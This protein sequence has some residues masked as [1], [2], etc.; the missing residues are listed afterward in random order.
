MSW[1]AIAT[2]LNGIDLSDPW[3]WF[4]L[5]G[6]VAF[7]SRFLVQWIASERA[8]DSV[9]PMA[10]WHL[11]IVGSLVMLVYAIHKRDPVFMLAYLPNAFVYVRNLML[12]KKNGKNETAPD[13]IGPLRS[14]SSPDVA[15]ARG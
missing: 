13:R 3:L 5:C 6:N 2:W 10:F 4:G 11:S 8:G 1:T 7:F 9:I 15:E 14:E 12:I